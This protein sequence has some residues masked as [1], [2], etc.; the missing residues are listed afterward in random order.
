MLNFGLYFKN[1]LKMLID[2][3]EPVGLHNREWYV[4]C[5]MLL[6]S[7]Y[8]IIIIIYYIFSNGITFICKYILIFYKLNNK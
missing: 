6:L 4:I 5:T 1:A 2:Q 7:Y 3:C 8:A